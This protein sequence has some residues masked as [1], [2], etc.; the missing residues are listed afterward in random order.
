MDIIFWIP[1]VL[2]VAIIAAPIYIWL[3]WDY[4]MTRFLL[5]GG[6]RR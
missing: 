3:D 2:V 4:G 5:N 1:I 6:R